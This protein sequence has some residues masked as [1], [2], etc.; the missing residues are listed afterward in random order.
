MSDKIISRFN[1]IIEISAKWPLSVI[2]TV[3]WSRILMII[4]FSLFQAYFSLKVEREVKSHTHTHLQT[5]LIMETITWTIHLSKQVG[6]K[7]FCYHFSYYL[8]T[9]PL[10][11][12]LDHPKDKQIETSSLNP[13]FFYLVN[14]QLVNISEFPDKIFF[15]EPRDSSKVTTPPIYPELSSSL[16]HKTF[17]SKFRKVLRKKDH[18]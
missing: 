9:E 6:L 4:N 7:G 15:S 14:L 2:F 1:W 5:G 16:E 17:S 8:A 13:F 11:D 10:L 18:R 12:Y 3:L